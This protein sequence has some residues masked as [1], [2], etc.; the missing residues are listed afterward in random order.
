MVEMVAT[1]NKTNF[2][3]VQSVTC[4]TCHHGRDLPTTTIAL[5]TLY[6]PP[7]EEHPDIVAPGQ[8]VPAATAILDKYIAALG[9]AQRLAGLTSFIATGTSLGYEGLGG[10]G[11]VQI[12]AKAP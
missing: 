1:I 12:V 11:V 4:F 6:G 3:G 9:G 10:G 5:D 2:A 8:G 7:S